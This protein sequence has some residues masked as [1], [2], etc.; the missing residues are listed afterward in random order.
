MFDYPP[1][2]RRVYVWAGLSL[3]ITSLGGLLG[4]DTTPVSGYS[5]E[6]SDTVILDNMMSR[7]LR[8][9]CSGEQWHRHR[10]GSRYRTGLMAP[11]APGLPGVVTCEH[12]NLDFGSGPSSQEYNQERRQDFIYFVYLYLL[13]K[14]IY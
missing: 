10:S 6:G 12:I 8:W 3:I 2:L 11:G 13:L 4:L 9:S 7:V 1:P 5:G 14:I